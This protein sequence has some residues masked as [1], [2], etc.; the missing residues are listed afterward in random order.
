MPAHLCALQG[1]LSLPK[2]II[3]FK[4]GQWDHLHLICGS[5]HLGCR[6]AWDA[7]LLEVFRHQCLQDREEAALQGG[8]AGRL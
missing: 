7:A 2:G 3:G 4:G 8:Q 1:S 6:H 5:L